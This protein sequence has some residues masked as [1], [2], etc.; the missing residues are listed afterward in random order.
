MLQIDSR[1][2]DASWTT[3]KTALLLLRA[4]NTE[5]SSSTVAWR[6]PHR[7]HSYRIVDDVTALHN[8]V[9]YTEMCL[10]D[11]SLGRIAYT[12]CSIV[13]WRKL[14]TKHGFPYIIACWEVFSEP[15]PGN[16]LIK[17]VTIH[18]IYIPPLNKPWLFYNIILLSSALAMRCFSGNFETSR[19]LFVAFLTTSYGHKPWNSKFEGDIPQAERFARVEK[20]FKWHPT[21]FL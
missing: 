18:T 5:N 4:P 8:T 7:K 21:K 12:R 11:R 13:A 14:H 16:A 10:P 6:G 17:S 2:I 15:L 19:R 20:T 9:R 3:Q 1:Y